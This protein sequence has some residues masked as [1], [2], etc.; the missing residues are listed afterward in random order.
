MLNLFVASLKSKYEISRSVHEEGEKAFREIDDDGD[1]ALDVR[2]ITKVFH[3]RG[4][5]LTAEEVG[6]AFAKIDKNGD[7]AITQDEFSSWSVPSCRANQV[8]NS[9]MIIY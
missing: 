1:G 5:T 6:R 8:A 7:G 2:E 3:D 4:V 9:P